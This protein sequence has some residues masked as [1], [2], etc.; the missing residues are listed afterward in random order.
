[1]IL[2]AL[3]GTLPLVRSGK[4]FSLPLQAHTTGMYHVPGFRS[5][6]ESI[7]GGLH[8][9]FYEVAVQCKLGRSHGLYCSEQRDPL[10]FIAPVH[11]GI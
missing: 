5:A 9:R 8:A 3:V 2:L 11:H 1:M 6:S 7:G 10:T 4:R